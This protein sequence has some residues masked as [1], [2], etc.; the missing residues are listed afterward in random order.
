MRCLHI[1]FHTL[2]SSHEVT[3][4]ILEGRLIHEIGTELGNGVVE[5]CHC[6][7]IKVRQER[8]PCCSGARAKTST[9]FGF[10]CGTLV[11]EVKKGLRVT[12][13]YDGITQAFDIAGV[14]DRDQLITPFST[15]TLVADLD[16]FGSL[17]VEGFS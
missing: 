8:I 12:K 1:I 17:Q 5:G 10:Q 16:L 9:K 2:T 7:S 11:V 4:L 14:E 15:G 6:I 3:A 13:F